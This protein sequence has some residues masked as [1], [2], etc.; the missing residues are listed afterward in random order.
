MHGLYQVY[1]TVEIRRVENVIVTDTKRRV[2]G[3]EGRASDKLCIRRM[4]CP[5]Q[6]LAVAWGAKDLR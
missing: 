3:S 4:L 2:H 6:T 5:A 1:C